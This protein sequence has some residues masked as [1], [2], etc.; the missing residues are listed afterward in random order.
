MAG[1]KVF[2]DK[3]LASIRK[4]FNVGSEDK[5][6]TMF[7]GQR[8][9]WKTHDKQGPY[10]SCDQKL[11]VDAVEE[12]KF[13]KHLKD[14]VACN[15]QMHTAYR[16]VLG[17]LNWLQSRTQVHL[18][19]KFSR[20]AS[21]AS[22]PTIGDVREINKVVH[23]MKSQYVDARFWP[24]KGNQRILGFPDAS[25]RNNS[26][27]SSQ[28]AHVIYLA[29]ERHP[30]NS[31]YSEKKDSSATRGSIIDYESH[32]IT[33]TTQ[34]TTLAELQ[35]L[36][37]CFGTCL[38]LRA[39][40]A[41]VS[42]QI[43]PIH[44]RTDA[45][46]LVTT[47]QTTHLPEQKET[48]HL[49]QMLRHEGNTGNIDD[50]SHVASEFCLADPLTKHTAKPDELVRSIETGTLRQV[51]VH[52]PFRTLVK[53]KAFITEWVIN[54]LPD[55]QFVLTFFA[56]D[57]SDC[58]Y[59]L[60]YAS[61]HFLVNFC[62]KKICVCD[63]IFGSSALL[64]TKTSL[65][66]V[67][68]IIMGRKIPAA[69]SETPVAPSQAPAAKS[70]PRSP[71]MPST[72]RP[73]LRS[74]RS[75]SLS[76]QSDS[77]QDDAATANAGRRFIDVVRASLL[78]ESGRKGTGR[79]S[80]RDQ[81]KGAG[82]GKR[83]T[84]REER[85]PT[86]ETVR[87]EG[88]R[89]EPQDIRGYRLHTVAHGDNIIVTQIDEIHRADRRHSG[90]KGKRAETPDRR[91][92]GGKGKRAASR[93]AE[94]RQPGKG[95][96]KGKSTSRDAGP[97]PSAMDSAFERPE[98]GVSSAFVYCLWMIW[99]GFFKFSDTALTATYESEIYDKISRELSWILRHSGWTHADQ[100]LSI[101]ELMAGAR[102]KKLLSQ[103]A[104]TCQSKEDP[105]FPVV[106]KA[107]LQP[108]CEHS[109]ERKDMLLPFAITIMYNQKGR[110]QVGIL[111]ATDYNK[112]EKFVS[113]PVSPGS[114]RPV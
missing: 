44:L 29:E 64:R 33:T 84:S 99:S 58:V 78:P 100:S 13:E 70:R 30:Y 68:V 23:T 107:Q 11:A 55:P 6:D 72:A 102:F 2:A 20:C 109:L 28:R 110:Y 4:D 73:V 85:L 3:V 24:L 62:V 97:R 90:G 77:P 45:N 108:W 32:K 10:I 89:Q 92:S 114:I 50:L 63:C 51:D 95:K 103:W 12:I 98:F 88:V 106:Q 48:H 81:S 101:F 18:R 5:N 83:S 91:H 52:P 41:D 38:F 53:H 96:G 25:Y 80:G 94:S 42:G 19:Y 1:D 61:C 14:N 105:V 16:S 31:R 8:I 65:S 75:V 34:S 59:S 15:P 57:I 27:K 46:N 74:R 104:H 87:R 36:M 112:G 111:S 21:A 71:S 66:I 47:A 82:K 79:H 60:M 26:D 113:S 9:K 76:R 43:L 54:N 86:V 49:I 69:A 35:A 37:R 7:V 17:Q 67:S 40:W 39:L 56:E 93:N 22:S